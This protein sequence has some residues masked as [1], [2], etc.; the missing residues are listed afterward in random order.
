MSSVR[1]DGKCQRCKSARV[2]MLNGKCSDM[3]SVNIGDREHE[4]Y[5]PRELG[6]GGGDYVD[7]S[8][9]LDCGQLQG[10]FP[11]PKHELEGAQDAEVEDVQCGECGWFNG[12]HK[13]TCSNE[14]KDAHV[15]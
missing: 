10:E 14:D 3:C 2:A 11:I 1:E 12:K 7:L 6:V 9:C 5:V 8:W 4:G 15:A 13:H